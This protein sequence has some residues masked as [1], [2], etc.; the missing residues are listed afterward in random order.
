[1]WEYTPIN[2][3]TGANTVIRDILSALLCA[4]LIGAP[5]AY[6]FIWVMQP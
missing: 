5:F 1:L 6:Y 3:A 4:V 2:N